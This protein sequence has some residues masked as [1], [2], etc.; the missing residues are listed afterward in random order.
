M[1][2]PV[3]IAEKRIA[4]AIGMPRIIMATRET[5]KIIDK[6]PIDITIP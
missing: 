3:T 1:L 5:I 6:I 2:S 4:N